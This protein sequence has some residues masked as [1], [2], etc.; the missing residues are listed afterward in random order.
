M[1][2]RKINDP[3]RI[4]AEKLFTSGNYLQK[5]VAELV[6]VT[7]KTI[8]DWIAKGDWKNRR[9][10]FTSTREN[11]IHMLLTQINNIQEQILQRDI[12]E[13][14]ATT[15]E[16]DQLA[17]LST[18]MKNM[19]VELGISDMISCGIRFIDYCKTVDFNKGKDIGLLFDGFLSTLLR[20]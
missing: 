12:K 13:R 3:K 6:G 20:R 2:G 15:K 1:G 11:Q 7:E 18:T 8:G 19:E 16:S 4:L 14:Y 10:S 17:K 5:E 9:A